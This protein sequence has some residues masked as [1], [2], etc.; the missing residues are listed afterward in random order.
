MRATVF[1]GP[2]DVRIE[3]APDA[4]LQAFVAGSD[5]FGWA[6]SAMKQNHTVT[7]SS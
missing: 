3:Q 5:A 6:T 2:F 4:A 7:R 1:R